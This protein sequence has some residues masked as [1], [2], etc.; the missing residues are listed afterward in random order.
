MRCS[1]ASAQDLQSVASSAISVPAIRN[2]TQAAF[3]SVG[4][5]R[6]EPMEP[7]GPAE[8]EPNLRNLWNQRNQSNLS[9]PY[10]CPRADI[11]PSQDFVAGSPLERSESHREERLAIGV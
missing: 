4:S 3:P 9:S 2:S 8:P 10:D 6:Q 5:A 11:Q 7:S 1:S